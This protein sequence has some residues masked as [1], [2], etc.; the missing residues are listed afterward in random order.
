MKQY[1][2]LIIDDSMPAITTLKEYL[3]QLSFFVEPQVCS[4]VAEAVSLLTHTSFDLILLNM[5]LPS[6]LEMLLLQA[7]ARPIP[8]ITTTAYNSF[9]IACYKLNI[10][11]CILKPYT[12]PRFTRAV[13]RALDIQS[14][15]DKSPKMKDELRVFWENLTA[16][17]KRDLSLLFNCAALREKP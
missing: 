4:S 13:N 7:F 9:A 11:D 5:R 8:I 14:R 3:N 12:F 16:D 17:H 10:V 15:V 2:C 1:Q 6:Q